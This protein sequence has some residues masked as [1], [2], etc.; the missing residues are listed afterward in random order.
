MKVRRKVPDAD[1]FKMTK[2]NMKSKEGW[3]QWMIDS[4]SYDSRK[5]LLYESKDT[6][7]F[8][9]RSSHGRLVLVMEDDW[10]IRYQDGRITSVPDTGLLALY[11]VVDDELFLVCDV[12]EA[13][14]DSMKFIEVMPD[15]LPKPTICSDDTA[16]EAGVGARL[17]YDIENTY[18]VMD[19]DGDGKV[20]YNVT[21]EYPEGVNKKVNGVW[22]VVYRENY[23]GVQSIR[24]GWPN[25]IIG[26]FHVVV[27]D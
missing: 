9:V 21:R 18:I 4:C 11:D 23:K 1:A 26:M 10:I 5:A 2:E 6:G 27:V 22:E 16:A 25:E 17:I 8:K 15:S 20:R 13:E 12:K 19:F 14:R 7:E 3:P 24:D